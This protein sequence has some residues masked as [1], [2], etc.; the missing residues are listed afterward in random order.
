MVNMSRIFREQA[1][2][3]ADGINFVDS[4]LRKKI[5]EKKIAMGHK[6]D[7]YEERTLQLQ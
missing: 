5:R 7:D 3:S 2:H 6:L 1:P 4:K